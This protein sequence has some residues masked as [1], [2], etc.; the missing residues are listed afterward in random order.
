[1]NKN[2]RS[3]LYYVVGVS[4][5]CLMIELRKR[6]EHDFYSLSRKHYDVQVAE[7]SKLEAE[8]VQVTLTYVQTPNKLQVKGGLRFFPREYFAS[9]HKF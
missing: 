4:L 2:L 5:V 3:V 6:S 7:P 9:L 8:P 1:M